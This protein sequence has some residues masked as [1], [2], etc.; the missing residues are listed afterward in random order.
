MVDVNRWM[1][2]KYD[3]QQQAL[4]NHAMEA[5]AQANLANTRAR[6]MPQQLSGELGYQSAQATNLRAQ[7]AHEQ[8]LTNILGMKAPPELLADFITTHGNG[9]TR[10]G[11]GSQTSSPGGMLGDMMHR[12]RRN[13]INTGMGSGRGSFAS[14]F[15]SSQGNLSDGSL[16][17]PDPMYRNHFSTGT[18]EVPGVGD[19]T[20]DTV[21]AKLAPKEAVLNR[22]AADLLGRDTIDAFNK[23]GQHLM[24]MGGEPAPAPAK[25]KGKKGFVKGTSSVPQASTPDNHTMLDMLVGMKLP[26]SNGVSAPGGRA[27]NYG[28]S[29]AESAQGASPSER[30]QGKTPGYRKGTSS[31]PAKKGMPPAKKKAAK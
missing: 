14:P 1:Q 25:A 18:A 27:F 22:A 30:G 29:P 28:N 21:D 3:Q 13:T 7:A 12:G 2:I 20:V 9:Y 26:P 16:V 4:D 15:A 31:V 6:L 8:Q 5:A 17:D 11:W 24:G 19:G 10:T 23:V